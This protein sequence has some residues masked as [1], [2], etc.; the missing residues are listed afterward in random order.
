MDVNYFFCQ[1]SG[2]KQEFWEDCSECQQSFCASHLSRHSCSISSVSSS[3]SS[4][5]SSASLPESEPQKKKQRSNRFDREVQKLETGAKREKGHFLSSL[6]AAEE[7]SDEDSSPESIPD[8]HLWSDY[9]KHHHAESSSESDADSASSLSPLPKTRAVRGSLHDCFTKISGT[10]TWQCTL[11][12]TSTKVRG[13]THQ[14]CSEFTLKNGWRHLSSW[15]P[16]LFLKLKDPNRTI[17]SPKLVEIYKKGPKNLA[18]ISDFFPPEQEAMLAFKLRWAL[19]FIVNHIPYSCAGRLFAEILQET[20][21]IDRSQHI[22]P[23]T[24]KSVYLPA[25]FRAV[26]QKLV[27]SLSEVSFVSLTYDGWTDIQNRK[28]LISTIH[29]VASDW[30]ARR[31]LLE[32]TPVEQSA[33]IPLLRKLISSAIKSK[34]GKDIGLAAITTDGAL[35]MTGSA[36]QISGDTLWCVCHRLHLVVVGS[37]SADREVAGIIDQIRTICKAFRGSTELSCLLRNAQD[38]SRPLRFSIDM[39]TR[40]NSTYTMISKFLRLYHVLLSLRGCDGFESPTIP[41]YSSIAKLQEILQPLSDITTMLQ[42]DGKLAET[43]YYLTSLRQSLTATASREFPRFVNALKCEFASRFDPELTTPSLI[44]RTS[45]LFPHPEGPGVTP[46]LQKQCWIKLIKDIDFLVPT[47]VSTQPVQ[48]V[49]PDSLLNFVDIP[50]TLSARDITIKSMIEALDELRRNWTHYGRGFHDEKPKEKCTCLEFWKAA[51]TQLT[52]LRPLA[53]MLLSIPPSS[54]ASESAAS[55]MGRIKS[56]LRASLLPKG[57]I[58]EVTI[59]LNRSLFGSR[60]EMI[61]QSIRLL[62]HSHHEEPSSSIDTSSGD[63]HPT[64]TDEE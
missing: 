42:G 14:S 23:R 54:A 45:L 27:S 58:Q 48:S 51:P 3:A 22:T 4:S 32:V 53:Q 8:S 31:A 44:T 33:T 18:T 61:E 47:A 56:K 62:K 19:F 41:V 2:C 11:P 50:L 55:V 49:A 26:Q 30:T 5:S 52:Q 38:V 24:L 43:Y 21:R 20:C 40:W 25:L 59:S 12:T 28:Y 39:P 29:F 1:F 13:R 34:T 64:A 63:E 16:D 37:I 9:Q 36:E 35:N 6:L 15:H 7:R 10:N 17:P 46:E 60:A 57:T